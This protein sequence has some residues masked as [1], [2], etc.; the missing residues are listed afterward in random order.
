MD[1]IINL[2]TKQDADCDDN[3]IEQGD[4]GNRLSVGK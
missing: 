3:G 2:F 4:M 1:W